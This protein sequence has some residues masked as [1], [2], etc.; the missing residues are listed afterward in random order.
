MKRVTALFRPALGTVCFLARG[1]PAAQQIC[2]Q[3][4]A[5]QNVQQRFRDLNKEA[6]RK[7]RISGSGSLLFRNSHM[8]DASANGHK[9]QLP[10]P[11]DTARKIP[12]TTLATAKAVPK[13]PVNRITTPKIEDYSRY[14]NSIRESNMWR[15]PAHPDTTWLKPHSASAYK[16][17][18]GNTEPHTLKL[19]FMRSPDEKSKDMANRDL[20]KA[21]QNKR[22][23]PGPAPISATVKVVRQANPFE[24]KFSRR[25]FMRSAF[26]FIDQK[27]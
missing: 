1:V 3:R 23:I 27:K 20:A 13:A 14:R 7:N 2:L 8:R 19:S 16:P 9:S 12:H 24:N 11:S 15:D 18:F 10:K 25:S 21:M 4:C 6:Q 17:D 22:F 5:C 26:E